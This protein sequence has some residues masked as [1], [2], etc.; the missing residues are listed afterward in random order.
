MKTPLFLLVTLTLLV[1]SLSARA[2]V[3]YVNETAAAGGDG[4]SWV[5]ACRYLQDALDLTNEGDEVWVAAGT[6]FPDEGSTVI[7]GDRTASFTLKQDVKL[8]GGFVG[9]ETTLGQQNPA[10]NGTILSGEIYSEELY[11][12]LHVV[13]LAG[14]AT[15]DGV[16]VTKGNANGE[17]AHFNQGGGIYAP[18]NLTAL[19]VSRCLFTDNKCVYTGNSDSSY[20]GAIYSSSSVTATNCTF[21]GNSAGLRGGAIYSSSVTVTNCTFTDNSASNFGGA[22]SSYSITA[23]NCA[24]TDNSTTSGYGGAIYASSAVTAK[25]CILSRN[26]ASSG[27]AISSSSVTA[28]N[29]MLSR[30]MASDGGAIRASSSVITTNCTFTENSASTSGGAI[31]SFSSSSSVA[32]TNCTFTENTSRAGGAISSASSSSLVTVTATNC[33]F[34]SNSAT[35]GSGGAISSSSTSFTVAHCTF[36]GNSAT[37]GYGGA[38]SSSS[39]KSFMV[40]N[41]TFTNNYASSLGGAIYSFSITAT[42]CTFTDNSVTSGSGGGGAIFSFSVAATNCMLS[43][44]TASYGGAIS[45]SFSLDS[46]VTATNCTFTENL[47]LGTEKKGGAI[48][49]SG[50]LKIFNNVIWHSLSEAQSNLI[51]ITATGSIRNADSNF[52]SPLNQA[53]NLIKGGMTSIMAEA[54]AVVSLGDTAVTLPSSDPLFMD[55]ANPVDPDGIWGTADDG[56]RLQETSPA[57]NLGLSMFLPE[58]V[59]DLDHDGDVTE[60]IPVDLAGYTRIQRGALDLGAYEAGDSALPIAILTQPES[61]TLLRELAATFTMTATGYALQYQWYLGNRGDVSN[62]ITGATGNS[63]TTPELTGSSSYWVRV[64][65]GLGQVDSQTA[66]ATVVPIIIT[67][68]PADTVTAPGGTA[69]LSVTASGR[70]LNHQWYQGLGGDTRNPIAGAILPAF[71]SPTLTETTTF[72]VRIS[73]SFGS[74]DSAVSTVTVAVDPVNVALNTPDTALFY[75]AG[76][77]APW[78][79]QS[80]TT[81]DGYVAAQSGAITDNQTSDLQTSV[82]GPG[83]ISFWWK[84]SS[85]SGGDYLRFYIDGAEQ[86]GR[87]SGTTGTWAKKTFN[88]TTSGDHTFRWAYTKNSYTSS[89]NDCG[90]V[91]EVTWSPALI[92]TQPTGRSILSGTDAE[93]EVITTGSGLSYQWFQGDSSETSAPVAGANSPSFTTPA[94]TSTSKFWVRVGDDVGYESSAAATVTVFPPNAAVATALDSGPAIS[95]FTWGDQPWIVQAATTHNGISALQ[96]GAITHSQTSHTEAVVNGAGTLS[97]WWKASSELGFDFVRFRVDGIEQGRLSGETGWQQVS[98]VVDGSETHT[99]SWSYEKDVSKSSG[100]D[101]VWLDQVSWQTAVTGSTFESWALTHEL[102]EDDA[103]LTANPSGDGVNN[104][105]K[106][107]LGLD[108]GVPTLTSTDGESPG[109]PKIEISEDFITFT[110]IKDAA[111]SDVTYTVEACTSLDDWEPVIEGLTEFPLAGSLVRVVVSVPVEEKRGFC[112]LKVSK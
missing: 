35:S 27:G 74:L 18:A 94:L 16:T 56:L 90:W 19:A 72:W 106:Y 51:Y 50:L 31:Y 60:L 78:F 7:T 65:N 20:G 83:T 42:N 103:L 53:K 43:R 17:L 85:Q 107:A 5:T 76:G 26:T 95:Y 66:T 58:D 102:T 47:A 13:T 105:M 71:T 57:Q 39:S 80:V 86:S 77:N 36:T 79:A 110:F 12:S 44:N 49:A 63:Y 73:N 28:M 59:Y 6:Y 98:I 33:T 111:K 93:L 48:Y 92:T 15:L 45:S 61:L 8:Y 14:N 38:I 46:S 87:I 10:T 1:F 23:T 30:N 41:C 69:A 21:T 70:N 88:V 81:H 112:R 24:F 3:V 4:T 82:T 9:Q 97:F 52:P 104:L 22:I 108:P 62:P 32:A 37:S 34:T 84:V 91:D 40:T 89:G 109:L 11:W 55:A 100:S 54:G 96:S 64:G 2:K 68:Q 99:L 101:Q 25:N 67:T 75:A 29:C